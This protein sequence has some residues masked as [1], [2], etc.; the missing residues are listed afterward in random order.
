MSRHPEP[1]SLGEA[2]SELI[3][4]RGLARKNSNRQLEQ[5]WKEIA[6]E[7]IASATHVL[8]LKRGVLEIAVENAAM[9]NEL[10]SFHRHRLLKELQGFDQRTRVRDV[11]FR[12]Q[13]RSDKF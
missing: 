9:L 5:V 8:G 7:R 13:R 6:G 4:V 3:R 11:R 12:L 1:G 2:I 10:V